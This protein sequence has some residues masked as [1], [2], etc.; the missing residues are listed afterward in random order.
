MQSY[1]PILEGD[2]IHWVDPPPES[3]GPIEVTIRILGPI[4]KEDLR[5]RRARAVAA[6]ARLAAEGGIQSIP[7]PAAWEREIRRDRPLPGR[8]DDEPAA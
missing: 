8:E 4:P 2:R 6:L 5:A 1:R 7:D 3:T